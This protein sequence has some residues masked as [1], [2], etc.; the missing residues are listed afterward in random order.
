MLYPKSNEK[1]ELYNLNG[2]WEY[3]FVN[4]DY[5]PKFRASG[6]KPMAVPSSYNE[7]VTGINE[8]EYCGK[9]Y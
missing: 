5:I 1:R 8:K 6:T 7:I 4:D 9:V 3:C 2:V